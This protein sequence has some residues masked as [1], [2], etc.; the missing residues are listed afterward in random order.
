[1][2]GFI[3]VRYTLTPNSTYIQQYSAIADLHIFQFTVAHALGFP[4]STSRFRAT[5]LNTQTI[6]VLPNHTLQMLLHY[7]T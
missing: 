7:S 1:M 5:D 3:S 6:R 4:V 2:I